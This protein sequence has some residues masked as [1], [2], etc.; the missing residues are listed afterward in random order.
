[1]E[2]SGEQQGHEVTV[3][4]QEDRIIYSTYQACASLFWSPMHCKLPNHHNKVLTGL[5]MDLLEIRGVDDI[6]LHHNN[7]QGILHSSYVS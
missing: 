7:H 3:D 5:H 6:A 1:M 4:R 2:T